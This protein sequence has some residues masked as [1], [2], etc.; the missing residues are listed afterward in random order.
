MES[1]Y[2]K[3]GKNMFIGATQSNDYKIYEYVAYDENNDSVLSIKPHS[4][5]STDAP[6]QIEVTCGPNFQHASTVHEELTAKEFWTVYKHA[7]L[8]LY[9]YAT[10]NAAKYV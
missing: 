9:E 6:V 8:K 10:A 1:N 5:F 3:F 4:T 2:T 7:V